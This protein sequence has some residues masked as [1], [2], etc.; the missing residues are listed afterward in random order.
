M[1]GDHMM[2]HKIVFYEGAIRIPLIIRPPGGI[3]GWKCQGL[4]DHLD[5]AATLMDIAGAKSLKESDGISL[6]PK[7]LKGLNDP[8]AQ[9]IKDV[10]FSEVYRFSMVRDERYKMTIKSNSRRP[11]ELFDLEE[12]PEE[13]INIVKDPSLKRIHKDLLNKYLNSLLSKLDK[14]KFEEIKL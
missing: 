11:V 14:K 1:L 9:K 13:L 12:D 10:V 2:R 6:L 7:L 3:K 8:N 5:I 4:T